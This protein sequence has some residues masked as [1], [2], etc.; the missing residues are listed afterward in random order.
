MTIP[1]LTSP[2]H[3]TA[4]HDLESFDCGILSLNDWLKRR[5]LN[6]EVNGASRSYVVCNGNTVVGYYCLSTGHAFRD[7]VPKSLQRNMP[8]P[9]PLVVLGRLAVDRDYQDRKIGSALLQDAVLRVLNV[10]DIAGVKA[11][12]VHAISD[13]AKSFYLSRGFL[14]SPIKPMT[15][16]FKLNPVRQLLAK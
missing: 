7:E 16:Y 8:D 6:N 13:E 15:L 5:A 4:A 2:V 10:A 12:L 3:L 11:I 14:E 9:I 1:G